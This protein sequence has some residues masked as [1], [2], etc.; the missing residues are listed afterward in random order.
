MQEQV[1]RKV[2]LLLLGDAAEA[3]ALRAALAPDLF[4]LTH[5]DV[6]SDVAA[7]LADLRPDLLI[8]GAVAAH[9]PQ[10]A[11][12]VPGATGSPPV[13]DLAAP[14]PVAPLPEALLECEQRVR[15]L[16]DATRDWVWETDDQHRITL[17]NDRIAALLGYTPEQVLHR[18][19]IELVW[20][21]DRERFIA[22]Q[23]QNLDAGAGWQQRRT[24]WLHASGAPRCLEGSAVARRAADGRV[25]GFR[26]V[27][28]DITPELQSVEKIGQLGR[29]YALLSEVGVA[30]ARATDLT[31][32]LQR[33]CQLAA[34]LTPFDAAAVFLPD[35]AGRL[36]LAA[37]A[38]DAALMRRIENLGPPDLSERGPQQRPVARVFLSACKEINADLADSPMSDEARARM[39]Q[40]GVGCQVVLPFGKPSWGVLSLYCSQPQT[41]DAEEIQVLERL[42]AELEHARG[43]LAKSER[44]EYLAYH[45]PLS[46]LPNRA[47][48]V[49]LA[50]PLVAAGTSFIGALDVAEFR[51]LH[52]ARGRRF[53]EQALAVIGRRLSEAL[54]PFARVA[55][56]GGEYF[57]FAGS[58]PDGTTAAQQRLTQL[59]EECVRSPVAIGADEV[60][61]S[62][63]CGLAFGPEHG[64]DVD[65]L[66]H[67]A[68]TAL[69]EAERFDAMLLAFSD[70]MRE[71]AARRQ[72]LERELRA[73]MHE[74]QFE[75]WLQPKFHVVNRQLSGAEALLR[76]QHPTLGPIAPNEFIPI[77][78][79][80]GLIVPTGEW[81]MRT[82]GA[83]RERWQSQHLG[84]PRIAVNI[85]A[86]ELRHAGFA[87][88][89]RHLL[90]APEVHTRLDVELTESLLMQDID[91]S[92]EVLESVRALGSRVAI[93]DFGTGFSSLNYLARLPVDELKIDQSFIAQ[94]AHSADTL[95]LVTNIL[96]LAHSLS[97]RVVAEGVETEEQEKLLRLLRCD[98]MQGYL[99]GR[100]MRA[101]EFEAQFLH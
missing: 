44:L 31:S 1:A 54:K 71:R 30:V 90:G 16:M 21:A 96:G 4:E 70:E 92:I 76:W 34:K 53:A 41:Y 51:R 13:V 33:A 17:S 74:Q 62:L 67:N 11:P 27:D 18:P 40:L 24:R 94:L 22:L 46:G 3:A 89:S 65:T 81:V 2:R 28:R 85:S 88:R 25:L 10:V 100:P 45:D 12:G 43:A 9:W 19:A 86:R 37:S 79:S 32:L 56:L 49:A 6:E 14:A 15:A 7:A 66:E 20:P 84:D 23:Q 5:V 73:A 59:L 38:G 42:A 8:R 98:E 48:F 75:L 97:L 29:F 82:A 61:F 72:L 52:G 91:H 83:L 63:R 93:D 95:A 69:A 35:G 57:Q 77:L 39:R 60:H 50:G 36:R 64:R 26:G 78:E 87:E 47:A 55:H 80:T 99:F 58:A 68:L 101:D